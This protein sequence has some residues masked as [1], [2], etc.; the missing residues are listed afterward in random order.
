MAK[1]LSLD[2]FSTAKSLGDSLVTAKAPSD[3]KRPLSLIQ[4]TI[5][6]KFSEIQKMS[7]SSPSSDHKSDLLAWLSAQ[8][9]SSQHSLFHFTDS[10]WTSILMQMYIH[11]YCNGNFTFAALA[12]PDKKL[13]KF[14]L[15]S[16]FTL[17]KVS[18]VLNSTEDCLE[19]ALRFGDNEEYCDS[20]ALSLEFLDNFDKVLLAFDE[21]SQGE[22]FKTP[23][24]VI[25]EG[26]KK[27]FVETPTWFRPCEPRSLAAWACCLLE[28]QIWGQFYSQKTS[29]NKEL[30]NVSSESLSMLVQSFCNIKQTKKLDEIFK[31]EVFEEKFNEYFN[32]LKNCPDFPI[33]LGLPSSDL[34][35][36]KDSQNNFQSIRSVR[37]I[38]DHLTKPEQYLVEYLFFSPLNRAG[39]LLD[40]VLRWLC[41]KIKELNHFFLAESL[42]SSENPTNHKRPSEKPAKPKPAKKSLTEKDYQEACRQVTQPLLTK[43]MKN[44]YLSIAENQPTPTEN[45]STQHQNS[46]NFIAKKN[47]PKPKYK[48]KLKKLS[49]PPKPSSKQAVQHKIPSE[50]DFPPLTS[51]I[52]KEAN[53]T[54]H[55][56]IIKYG[57]STSRKVQDKFQ[58][59]CM[60]LH[61]LEI[62]IAE[63]LGGC[64]RLYGS[65]ATGLAIESSDIDLGIIGVDIHNRQLLYEACNALNACLRFLP[66]VISINPILTAKVPVIKVQVDLQSFS[67]V[68]SPLL[69]DISFVETYECVHQGFQAIS[70]TKNLLVLFP[71][72][73]YLTMVLKNFLYSINLNSSYYGNL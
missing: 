61:K 66:F 37:C 5:H 73:R 7:I 58:F 50:K 16:L 21:I 29:L 39:S 10:F 69:V 12:R 8:P 18:K 6:Q 22:C 56:E 46:K 60:M 67:G 49:K 47:P 59:I 34:Y 44:L 38:M 17:K 68:P 25:H 36:A 28:K 3:K 63:Q 15:K 4:S 52:L 14:E 40:L 24:R 41:M 2:S 30:Q 54:L 19:N 65:Y 11:K 43:I 51:T 57:D 70:F 20:L 55:Q 13:A 48:K 27:T 64:I 9:S 23:C 31:Q 42:I 32:Q 33:F 53:D 35:K 26:Q 71:S 1:L 72:I 45:P 62:V